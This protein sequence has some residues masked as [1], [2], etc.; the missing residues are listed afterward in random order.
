MKKKIWLGIAALIVIGISFG[1]YNMSSPKKPVIADSTDSALQFEVTR[2]NLA[3]T[4]DVKGKSS[5]LN[6]TI[7]YAPYDADVVSWHVKDGMQIKKGTTLFSLDRTKIN[8]EISQLEA[9]LEKSALEARL[10][11]LQ[12]NTADMG[13]DLALNEAEAKRGFAEREKNKIMN[14]LNQVNDQINQTELN[15]KKKKLLQSE[16]K[17]S[18]PGIFLF[19][20]ANNIPKAVRENDRIG[21]VVDLDK[22]QLVTFVGEQDVFQIKTGMPVKVKINAL[23]DIVLDGKVE[24]VSKFAKTGTE[25]NTT[26]QAAQFQVNISLSKNENLIAGLSLTGSIEVANKPNVLVIPTIAIQR[27]K[28]QYYVNLKTATG[29]EKKYIKIGLET[30]DKT[31]VTEGLKEKDTVILQ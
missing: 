23:K 9:Q 1:L 5:Y 22:L 24:S 18:K 14:D 6:E 19:D 13:A 15:A 27:E 30:S 20:D 25:Q 4:I 7:V 21:K 2:E 3:K 17:T 28:D 29:V 11:D 10:N 26:A 31:E 16:F 12:A 8:N